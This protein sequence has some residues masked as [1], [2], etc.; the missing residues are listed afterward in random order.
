[1]TTKPQVFMAVEKDPRAIK[2]RRAM[3]RKVKAKKLKA[4]RLKVKVRKA[5][6]VKIFPPASMDLRRSRVGLFNQEIAKKRIADSLITTL[7][8]P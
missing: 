2:A 8:A 5:T 6:G 1:M 3:V 7:L 4:A